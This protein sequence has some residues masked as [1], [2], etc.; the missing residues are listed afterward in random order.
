MADSRADQTA[1]GG[2]A[3]RANAGS[4]LACAQRPTGATR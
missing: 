1:S 3:E 4:F 2:T